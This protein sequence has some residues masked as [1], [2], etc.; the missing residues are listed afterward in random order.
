MIINDND[1]SLLLCD[2]IPLT[3]RRSNRPPTNTCSAN[4][5]ANARFASVFSR[6]VIVDSPSNM[7]RPDGFGGRF[8]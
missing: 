6:S 2:G 3:E 1:I 8:I 7:V 4:A 5:P